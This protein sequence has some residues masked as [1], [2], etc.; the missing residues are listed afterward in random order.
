M[1][2]RYH[3][4]THN[5]LNGINYYNSRLYRHGEIWWNTWKGNGRSIASVEMAIRPM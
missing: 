2:Y 5:R 4:C 3:A 1:S